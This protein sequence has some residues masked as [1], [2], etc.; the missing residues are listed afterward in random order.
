MSTD[1][2]DFMKHT[3]GRGFSVKHSSIQDTQLY[4]TG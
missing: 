2:S 4:D 3:D 1:V